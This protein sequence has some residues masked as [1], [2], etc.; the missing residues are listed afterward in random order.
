MQLSAESILIFPEILWSLQ[1]THLCKTKYIT[2][3]PVYLLRAGSMPSFSD[4]K[5]DVFLNVRDK[6]LMSL[7]SDKWHFQLL[8]N[9]EA[10]RWKHR[11][12]ATSVQANFHSAATSVYMETGDIKFS[13]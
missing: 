3:N 5:G 7:Y 4:D 12:N 8:S 13:V 1:K 11:Y 10:Y 2:T 6:S 9:T